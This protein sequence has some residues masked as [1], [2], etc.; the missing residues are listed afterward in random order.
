SSVSCHAAHRRPL[1]ETFYHLFGRALIEP[2]VLWDYHQ[3]TLD[4]ADVVPA[5]VQP[6][7][8]NHICHIA[9]VPF[10][11][12]DDAVE[13]QKL[14]ELLLTVLDLLV[15]SGPGVH[16]F[17][18]GLGSD[19]VGGIFS[20][21]SGLKLTRQARRERREGIGAVA[22]EPARGRLWSGQAH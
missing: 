4:P 18:C 14:S 11:S 9:L 3:L 13:S 15:K 8:V 16:Q 5:L 2:I 1:P 6:Q 17:G 10:R 20:Q 19:R 12:L 22:T 21:A 7:V